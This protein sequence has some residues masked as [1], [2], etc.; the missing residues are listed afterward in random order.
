MENFEKIITN[1]NNNGLLTCQ[2]CGCKMIGYAGDDICSD[3][4]FPALA[5]FREK[6]KVEFAKNPNLNIIQKNE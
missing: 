2:K 6:M 1:I 3:C 4:A 5:K